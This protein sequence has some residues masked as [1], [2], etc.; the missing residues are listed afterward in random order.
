[1]KN[2]PD[3]APSLAQ[4]RQ[5]EF[6][7]AF[8]YQPD[9]YSC[10]DLINSFHPDDYPRYVGPTCGALA[11][12]LNT[13]WPDPGWPRKS[14]LQSLHRS[15]FR[16][17]KPSSWR[18]VRVV[19]GRHRPPGPEQVPQLMRELEA[20]YR[21]RPVTEETLTQWYRDFETIHPFVDGNGRVGGCVVALLS[22]RLNFQ[23]GQY[24]TPLA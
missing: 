12:R 1:M 18:I 21:L 13:K 17:D 2:S 19:V 7:P 5:D 8:L 24:L 15:I 6:H 16:G 20:A 4:L 9:V 14:H 22:H 3:R 10:A 11:S 23:N